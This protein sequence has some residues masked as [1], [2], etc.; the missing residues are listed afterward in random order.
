MSAGLLT[1]TW[2][3]GSTAPEVSLTTPAML[4]WA[5]A[6]PGSR[7]SINDDA[8]TSGTIRNPIIET[9]SRVSMARQAGGGRNYL[10]TGATG[11]GF[12]NRDASI[13][14]FGCT[15][16]SSTCACMYVWVTLRS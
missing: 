16:V 14:A 12:A 7:R 9:S 5:D 10:V 8:T 13:A 15:L 6:A 4:L 11:A 2:T 1:S 3:P